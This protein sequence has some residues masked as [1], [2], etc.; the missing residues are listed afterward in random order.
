MVI[1][2]LYGDP[3]RGQRGLAALAGSCCHRL[4]QK[5]SL[6]QEGLFQLERLEVGRGISVGVCPGDWEAEGSAG[7]VVGEFMIILGSPGEVYLSPGSGFLAKAFLHIIFEYCCEHS[8]RISA[9]HPF[10]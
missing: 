3:A 4:R 9:L 1:L 5:L 8:G 7:A 2:S 10:Y 6:S